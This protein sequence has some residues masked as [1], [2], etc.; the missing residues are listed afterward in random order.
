M[1]GYTRTYAYDKMGNILQL[2]QTAGNTPV[3]STGGKLKCMSVYLS[4]CEPRMG[5]KIVA[6]GDAR[7]ERAINVSKTQKWVA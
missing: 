1:H 7:S 6:T 3:T 2:K 5:G 4:D